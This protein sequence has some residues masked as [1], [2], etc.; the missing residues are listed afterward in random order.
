MPLEILPRP[1]DR[2]NAGDL[3]GISE[4]TD[5][6]IETVM[7]MEFQ[8]SYGIVSWLCLDCRME[9]YELIQGHPLTREYELASFK[10]EFWR[11]RVGEQT[12]PQELD[13]GIELLNNVN[14]LE[15]KMNKLTRD[16]L[17]SGLSRAQRKLRI[18][19]REQLIRDSRL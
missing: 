11:S 1:C 2:C 16:W 14:S 4:Y 13:T 7:A 12:P 10:L 17:N 6:E 15:D 9:W 19:K 18:D 8:M 5:L 3:S